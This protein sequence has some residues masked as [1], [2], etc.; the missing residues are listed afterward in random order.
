MDLI[1]KYAI[2]AILF[3][4]SSSAWSSGIVN[5]STVSYVQVNS[6]QERAYIKFTS[7]PATP[8]SCATDPRMSIDLMT[9]AGRAMLSIALTAKASGKQLFAAGHGACFSNYEEIHY[10]RLL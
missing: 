9:H 7:D 10:I 4:S 6:S 5:S 3:A 2:F 1:Y 8:P